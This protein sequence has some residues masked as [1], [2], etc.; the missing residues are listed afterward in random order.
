MS[1]LQK[2]SKQ[3]YAEVLPDILKQHGITNRMAGPRIDKVCL[4]MGVGRAVADGQILNVVSE[5]LSLIAG[6]KATV[7]K[8]KKAVA[9]FRTRIGVKLGARVTLRGERMWSFLDK[10]IHLAVPRIKDFRG[11]SPK[12]FDGK[13]NYNMGLREQ[14]LF[15]EIVLD[16]LEH[17][18]G[19]NI[20]ICIRNSNDV[21]SKDLLKALRMPFR[22][23]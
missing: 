9:N 18:Q 19:L 11:L 7:T 13:G 17:N 20:T 10:L 1:T 8:A 6:Q 21:V 3:L 4:S 15:H 14:A 16:K 5:H 12:G 23:K 2:T 22:E